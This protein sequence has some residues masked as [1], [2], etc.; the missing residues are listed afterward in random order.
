[1]SQTAEAVVLAVLIIATSVWLGGYVALVVV[2]R[3]ATQTLDPGA[4]AAFFRTLGRRFFWVSVPAL[5]IALIAGCVL[6]RDTAK[7]GLFAAIVAVVAVMLVS[8][9]IAVAQ[10]RRMTRLRRALLQTPTDQPLRTRVA[11]GARAAGALRAGLGL[12]S[13]ALV[14]LGSFVAVR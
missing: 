7:D 12:L 3:V 14:V 10:A 11:T 1:M 4:R 8:F 2:A 9:A 5:V 6:A 13:L